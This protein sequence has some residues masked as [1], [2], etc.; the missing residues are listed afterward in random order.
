[1]KNIVRKKA[2]KRVRA[3][4][5]AKKRVRAGKRARYKWRKKENKNRGRRGDKESNKESEIA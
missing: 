4:K 1:M 2:K 3:R 5:K